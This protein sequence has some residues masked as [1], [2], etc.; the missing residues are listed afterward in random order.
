MTTPSHSEIEEIARKEVARWMAHARHDGQGDMEAVKRE[1]EKRTHGGK[2]VKIVV[3][4]SH[5]EVAAAIKEEIRNE[6]HEDVEAYYQQLEPHR[7]VWSYAF[8]TFYSIAYSLFP[9][10]QHEFGSQSFFEPFKHGLGFYVNLGNFAVGVMMPM[11]KLDMESRIHC[12]DGPA[13]VWG[14]DEQ[15][16]W[17]GVQVPKEWIM[18][19]ESLDPTMALTHGNVE[20]RRVLTEI[21][22]WDR[23]IEGFEHR[24]IDQDESP[25][26]GDLIEVDLSGHFEDEPPAR[27]LRVL[28][29]TGRIFTLC[30]D[31]K[32]NTALEAN[33]Y[34]QGITT[35]QLRA[36]TVRT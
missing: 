4:R 27:F 28:C 3:V 34:H 23:I 15:Y 32:F 29:G 31:P 1:L 12:Q 2:P 9:E 18:A 11:V 6:G 13:I 20:T 30:V 36:M 14:D 33:A 17:R 21:I 5:K 7:C 8:M 24:V 26:V 19:P 22:G 25:Y 16:W 35:E 10:H